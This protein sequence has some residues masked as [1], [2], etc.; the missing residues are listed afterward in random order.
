M[1]RDTR[2]NV[3]SSNFCWQDDVAQNHFQVR[4]LSRHCWHLEMTLL[5]SCCLLALGDDIA[6]ILF[7][8]CS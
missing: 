4:L 2:T 1:F 5:G 7:L 6:H 3:V 8:G